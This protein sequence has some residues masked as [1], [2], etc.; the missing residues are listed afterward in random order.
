M[1]YYLWLSE[2]YLK[3]FTV[4]H[5]Y[6]KSGNTFFFLHSLADG[7]VTYCAALHMICFIFKSIKNIH[8]YTFMLSFEGNMADNYVTKMYDYC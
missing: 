7:C 4:Y 6:I 3:C 2:I 5:L 8:I 1:F